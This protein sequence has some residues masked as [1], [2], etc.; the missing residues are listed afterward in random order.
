MVFHERGSKI[1]IM[2]VS[3]IDYMDIWSTEFCEVNFIKIDTW[4]TNRKPL[5]NQF[6]YFIFK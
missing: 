6:E 3:P 5:E 4:K 2:P 1:G